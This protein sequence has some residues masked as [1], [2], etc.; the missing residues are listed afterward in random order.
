MNKSGTEP[1]VWPARLPKEKK[2]KKKR[3]GFVGKD[4]GVQMK[5]GE[6]KA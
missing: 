3:T 4:L 2:G 1:F 5:A 6:I